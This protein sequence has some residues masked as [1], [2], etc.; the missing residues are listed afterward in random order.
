M[1]SVRWR[2]CYL[3]AALM[4]SGCTPH[5]RAK[6][7]PEPVPPPATTHRVSERPKLLVVLVIDQLRA[8]YLDRM[9]DLLVD[10]GFRAFLDG[11]ANYASCRLRHLPSYTG[12][13]HAAI[14]T[15]ACPDGNGIVGNE[16]WNP[17]AGQVEYC[18]DQP[19]ATILGEPSEIGAKR[20]GPENL[21]TTTLGDEL[22]M[23][24][25]GRA[26][27]VSIALKDRAAILM[28][29]R[30]ADAALWYDQ[31]KGAWIT[32]TAYGRKLPDW[33]AAVNAERYP[34]L[35]RGKR[36]KPLMTADQARARGGFETVWGER[37]GT[38]SAAI[39][40]DAVNSKVEETTE[41]YFGVFTQTPRANDYTLLTALA[42]VRAERLGARDTTDLL[43]VSLSSTDYVGHKYGPNSWEALDFTLQTDRALAGFLKELGALVPGGLGACTL[44]LTA[45]HGVAPAPAQA[46]L[47]GLPALRIDDKKLLDEAR[48]VV[49][50]RFQ[51]GALV[52]SWTEP[53]LTIDRAAVRR[54]GLDLEAVQAA[55]AEGVMR[56]EGVSSAWPVTR[57]LRGQ[58]PPTVLGARLAHAVHPDVSGDVLV[59]LDPLCLAGDTKY[60]TSHGQAYVYDSAVPLLFA[61]RG[62]K[63][64]VD[65]SEAST[66]DIAPTFAALAGI[67]PPASCEGRVLP[68]VVPVR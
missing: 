29:G 49:A 24:T 1:R 19:G 67:L 36:W 57:L 14:S 23:A 25:G 50:A 9:R 33:A 35:Q 40:A 66:L 62:I 60:A 21:R 52:T 59:L 68:C 44:A 39:F 16:W 42:A 58:V 5:G 53:Y 46:A 4:V 6:A 15:G 63:A 48:A 54:A 17:N 38:Q 2:V 13:G 7:K 47:M 41:A 34:A 26:K 20:V 31:G 45:D 3:A 11:G 37:F 18:V 22:K 8:D 56:V 12:P 61:G 30:L 10:G 28:G 27:V 32:S 43:F 55:A 65:Y 64:G 51:N